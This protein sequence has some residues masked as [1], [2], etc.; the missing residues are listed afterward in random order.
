MRVRPG[1]LA[2]LC[3]KNL[4]FCSP[5]RVSRPLPEGLVGTGLSEA[6]KSFPVETKSFVYAFCCRIQVRIDILVKNKNNNNFH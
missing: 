4:G 5:I 3:D 1:F 2:V 6:P